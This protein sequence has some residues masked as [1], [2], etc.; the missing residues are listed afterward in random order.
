MLQEATQHK[1]AV[2]YLIDY[3]KLFNSQLTHKQL[4]S[5]VIEVLQFDPSTQQIYASFEQLLE[6]MIE[7]RRTE[8]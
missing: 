6:K 8:I 2:E 4:M 1:T 7:R 3:K 5:F